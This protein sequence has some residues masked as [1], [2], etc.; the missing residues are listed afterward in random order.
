MTV[1]QCDSVTSQV[2]FDRGTGLS[3]CMESVMDK[4]QA[5]AWHK[6]TQEIRARYPR[7]FPRPVGFSCPPAW[8]EIIEDALRQLEK[9]AERMG[10]PDDLYPHITDIKEKYGTLRI[11]HD[12]YSPAGDDSFDRIVEEAEARSERTCI[13]CGEPGYIKEG[14]LWC[15]CDAHRPAVENDF[16]L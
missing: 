11:Y 3:V 8:A 4:Q 13:V 9:A 10:L 14:G 6:K 2:T 5:E 1:T 7:L 16:V 15:Y 12:D